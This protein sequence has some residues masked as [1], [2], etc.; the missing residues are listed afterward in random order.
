MTSSESDIRYRNEGFRPDPKKRFMDQVREVLRYHHYSLETE[1]SY[2]GWIVRFIHFHG[3][4]HPQEMGEREVE[5]FLSDLASVRQC[6]VNTQKQALNA[7]VFLYKKVLGRELAQ[8]IR[9]Q[10]PSR[11]RR[12][13]TVLSKDEV[14][15]LLAGIVGAEWN[16]M[17]RLLYGSGLRLGEL[18]SLRV[19]DIDLATGLILVRAGKGRKD[20]SAPLPRSLTAALQEQLAKTKAIHQRDREAGVNGVAMPEALARKYP[21]AGREWAWQW[22]FPMRELS[23]D[24]RSGVIRRHH[25]LEDS[26][27]RVVAEAARRVLPG[28]RVSPHT[29]RH[30]FATHLLEA[31]TDLRTLQELLGH[32]D[33]KTTEIYT[34]VVAARKRGIVSPLDSE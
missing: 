1:R 17:V 30:S 12:L 28:R 34:H 21:N 2:C 18:C 19:K 32:A 14:K 8:T 23:Q 20:R 27:G 9:P 5:G 3:K 26:F 16:L 22:L 31:G 24:P 4:R 6:S 15:L 25:C 10:V 7:L 33:V 29:L 11:G 13:P